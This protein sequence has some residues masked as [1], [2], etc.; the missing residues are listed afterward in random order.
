MSIVNE[1]QCT[2]LGLGV[3]F[4]RWREKQLMHLRQ[5]MVKWIEF[6]L[7][8]LADPKLSSLVD[9]YTEKTTLGKS[10]QYKLRLFQWKARQTP[11]G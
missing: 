7:S 11:F 4:G 5:Y 6:G 1:I 2:W 10:K 8:L 3:K 9:N